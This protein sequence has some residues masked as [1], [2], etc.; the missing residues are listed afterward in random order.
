M[1][2]VTRIFD[3]QAPAPVPSKAP[4]AAGIRS[5]RIDVPRNGQPYTF[6]KV[7]N[8]GGE[9][10]SVQMAIMDGGVF[11][12]ARS[13]AQFTAFLLGLTLCW[14]SWNSRHNLKLAAGL[15]LTLASMTAL[16]VS[17]RTLHLVMIIL[18]PFFLV[19]GV[20]LV[21][22]KLWRKA[23]GTE[24]IPPAAGTP[25]AIVASIALLLTLTGLGAQ[26]AEASREPAPI[27]TS[28]T[29]TGAIGEHAGQFEGLIHITSNATNQTLELFGEEIALREFSVKTGDA[30]LQREGGKVSVLLSH[31]GEALLSVKFLA[32]LGGTVSKR[33]LSF[34]LPPALSSRLNAT[35]EEPEADVEFA[36]A[37]AFQRKSDGQ[38]TRVEAVIGSDDRVDL[39]WTPRVKRAA[40]I[41]ASVFAENRS[42]VSF[43]GGVINTRALFNYQ[44]T[45][46]E[47]RQARVLLPAKQ[48][49]LRVEGE[50][51]RTWELKSENGR[52]VLVVEL[53]KGMSPAWSL[54]IE[55]ERLLET[56]PALDAVELP[57]ALDVK[58]ENGMLA[59]RASEEI[60]LSIENAGDLQ[61]VDSAEFAAAEPE[62]AT[63]IFTAYRFLKA[64]FQLGVKVESVQP[65]IEAVVRN[66]VRIDTDQLTL[67][68]QINYTIKKAGI[69]GLK[70]ALPKSL[71]VQSLIGEGIQQWSSVPGQT[72][73]DQVLEV[74]FSGRTIGDTR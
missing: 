44:I 14:R 63:E 28:A 18:P 65:K 50:S 67:G 33:Q 9:P 13:G 39:Q 4:V 17:M 6:T 52:E 10:L 48:R 16:M 34:R 46:G 49:L 20:I 30:K 1:A 3:A 15:A 61:R 51:I 24:P 7:L 11:A 26:G 5:I 41:A 27:I 70:V 69:F 62:K 72:Q 56:L 36:T 12:T 66:Q 37:V 57:H 38:Q 71:H 19:I 43:G 64:D 53:L 25:P 74:T 21:T 45:Q 59:L 47:L 58:R 29:Y 42:T 32:K 40:E 35:I 23:P 8:L 2:E 60:S 54:S 31:P 68:A 55:T 73:E 22:W